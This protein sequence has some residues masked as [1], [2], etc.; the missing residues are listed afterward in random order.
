[1]GFSALTCPS[2]VETVFPPPGMGMVLSAREFMT[3][4]RKEGGVEGMVRVTFP[5][6]LF[7]ETPSA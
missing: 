2:L 7:S 3:C 6:L 5:F 4:F 1:M